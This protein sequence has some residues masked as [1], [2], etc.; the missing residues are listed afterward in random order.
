MSKLNALMT[1]TGSIAIMQ[2]VDIVNTSSITEI[3][4][5]VSLVLQIVVA[6]VTVYKLFSG[7]K[8]IN[9]KKQDYEN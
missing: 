3:K 1:G 9:F 8:K 5:I 6:V 2:G 7:E 4:D